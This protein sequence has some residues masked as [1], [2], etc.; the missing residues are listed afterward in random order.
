MRAVICFQD[1][2]YCFIFR[3]EKCL[4]SW[5]KVEGKPAE[6]VCRPLC[7]SL[8]PHSEEGNHHHQIASVRFYLSTLTVISPGF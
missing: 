5:Q 3:S 8:L 7:K 1:S 6:T 2:T 4:L